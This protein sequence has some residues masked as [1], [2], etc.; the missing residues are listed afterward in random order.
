MLS[1]VDWNGKK[2][3]QVQGKKKKSSGYQDN[4][5]FALAHFLGAGPLCHRSLG[6]WVP[7]ALFITPSVD[8]CFGLVFGAE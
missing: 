1:I 6:A 8:G 4:A 7:Y 5:A 2:G 3:Q